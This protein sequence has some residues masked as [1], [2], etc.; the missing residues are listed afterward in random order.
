MQIQIN[1]DR[2]I[3]A[4]ERLAEIVRDTLQNKLSRFADHITRIEVHF[5]DEN[6]NTKHDGSDK[7]CMLEARF[8]GLDPVA[9]T[10]HAA[11]VNQA[12][13]GAADKMQRKLSS[14]VGKL[15]DKH[16]RATTPEFAEPDEVI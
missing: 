4:D 5:S 14:V 10:E 7:R 8:E 12:L 11:T 6:G 9:I 15:R 1:S 16:V 2:N 13:T 3:Q